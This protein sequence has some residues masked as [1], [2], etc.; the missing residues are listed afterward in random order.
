MRLYER[1][2]AFKVE[3]ACRIA[4]KD[5][6]QRHHLENSPRS[7]Y[8]TKVKFLEGT[9]AIRQQ[10]NAPWSSSWPPHSLKRL[11]M[12]ETEILMATDV[13]MTKLNGRICVCTRSLFSEMAR[14]SLSMEDDVVVVLEQIRKISKEDLK[15]C[16]RLD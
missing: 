7:T 16:I 15:T 4:S 5:N 10:V 9:W 6:E 14:L 3:F 1:S 2:K 13:L 11:K 8:S 12:I